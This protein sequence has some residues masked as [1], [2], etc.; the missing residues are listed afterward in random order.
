MDRDAPASR[1]RRELRLARRGGALE[2]LALPA[3]LFETVARL[4]GGLYERGWLASERVDAPVVSLGNLSVGGTG[5]TPAV[6]WAARELGL[7]GRKPGIASRGYGARAGETSDEALSLARELPDVPHA[8]HPRRVEAA[9]ALL[10]RG[11]D[12]VVLDD[13]V[14]HRA[15][16]RD[17]DLVLVDAS[18]PWGLPSVVAGVPPVCALLPRGLLREPPSALARADAVIVTRADQVAPRELEVLRE[19]LEEL[20]PGRT[21]AT[22]EHRPRGL[23]RLESGDAGALDSL[24]GA[25][26]ELVSGIGNPEAFERSV[27]AL[28]AEVASHRRFPDHHAYAEA[29]LTG[30]HGRVVTT[31]KDAVKLAALDAARRL[32]AW[33]LEVEFALTSGAPALGALF[34][35]LAPSRAERERAALH[36]GLAG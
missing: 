15:L 32:D 35:A 9:R 29:D 14:Q 6:A 8:A 28:G 3:A 17:L 18:R 25:Q 26:V 33:V 2:L 20:A 34:D 1:E 19:R 24:A 11:C 36:G 4:R 31:T 16:A 22:A 13:G 27:R 30:L 21:V 5:K 10:A 7:R 12:V 23:R